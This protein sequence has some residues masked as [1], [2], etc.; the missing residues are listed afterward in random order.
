[1]IDTIIKVDKFDYFKY[2][3]V[4]INYDVSSPVVCFFNLKAPKVRNKR[5][6]KKY[7]SGCSSV[8]DLQSFLIKQNLIVN[9]LK[10]Y[11]NKYVTYEIIP[12]KT[13][14]IN[15]NIKKLQEKINEN[16]DNFDDLN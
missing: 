1:M 14:I 11:M 12:K 10:N 6:I 7:I 9:P 2:D 13:F 8:V 5:E 15:Q 16:N 3:F 4:M